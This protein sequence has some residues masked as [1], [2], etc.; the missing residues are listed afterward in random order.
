[1]RALIYLHTVV[2][3]EREV[4]QTLKCKVKKQRDKQE[5]IDLRRENK[6][7]K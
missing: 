6:A 5:K 1:M 2:T 4:K 7:A 3:A